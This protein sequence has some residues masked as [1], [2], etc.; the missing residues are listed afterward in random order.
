[1]SVVLL[2]ALGCEAEAPPADVN[3]PPSRPVH[4]PTSRPGAGPPGGGAPGGPGNTGVVVEEPSE[5]WNEALAVAVPP[6]PAAS[7]CPDADGDGYPS[8]VACP[9]TPPD[10]A[11]CDDHDGTVSPDTERWVPPGPFVMGSTSTAAGRDE[12]PVHVVTLS[13]YCL[14]RLEAARGDGTAVDDI[15]WD[16]AR[17]RCEA[18]GKALPTEAQ[19]EK[20][21]RGGCE[22]GTD[23]ARCDPS[24]LRP[25]PWGTGA[26]SCERANHQL[27]A[28]GLALCVGRVEPATT[29]RNTGPYGHVNLAGN[30]WEWVADAYAPNVYQLQTP[31]VDPTGP[32]SGTIHVLRGGGWNTFPTNMRVANRFTSVVAG[33]AAGFRCARATVPGTPDEV[34]PLDLVTL[35]GTVTSSTPIAG[36]QLNLSAFDAADLDAHTRRPAPGRSPAAEAALPAD[37]S[38]SIPFSLEVPRGSRYLVT[39]ALDAGRQKGPDGAYI[40]RSGSGGAGE[41][42]GLVEAN[43]DV[44][45]ISV[46]LAVRPD[47]NANRAPGGGAPSGAPGPAGNPGPAGRPAAPAGR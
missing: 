42:A 14:D 33:S 30:A 8:A 24:D 13:G 28:G 36:V 7:D 22:L 39:A 41:A 44:S 9:A 16:D 46:V 31:R 32:R 11:D 4:A 20:A 23:P 29:A 2:F 6:L 17:G 37:G 27:A 15:A 1:M 26:P 45:G 19:W 34:A 5:S 40:S 21:A 3:R 25:Y 35:R 10:R 12:G 18:Q 38:T 47:P 43:D